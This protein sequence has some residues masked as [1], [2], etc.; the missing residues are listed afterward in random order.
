[1]SVEAAAARGGTIVGQRDRS[2]A[3]IFGGGGGKG[4]G[5][6]RSAVIGGGRRRDKVVQRRDDLFKKNQSILDMIHLL[7]D[8]GSIVFESC[9]QIA[10]SI[11]FIVFCRVSVDGIVNRRDLSN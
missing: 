4:G 6:W 7:Q 5:R 8:I 11:V 10:F 3:F 2:D 1:M 9:R